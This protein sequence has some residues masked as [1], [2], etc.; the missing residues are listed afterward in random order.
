MLDDA[1]PAEVATVAQ[2]C[3]REGN[4]DRLEDAGQYLVAYARRQRGERE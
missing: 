4:Y 1:D 2:L 3:V